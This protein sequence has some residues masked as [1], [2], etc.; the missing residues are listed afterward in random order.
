MLVVP[1]VLGSLVSGPS[2]RQGL[3]LI[4]WL[5]GY[6]AFFTTGVWLRSR[7]K[8]R[9]LPPVRVYATAELVL[10]AALL[11]SAPR[12]LHWAPAYAVLLTASLLASVRRADRSW[13][14]DVVT[15]AAASL[16]AAVAAGL[17][18][19]PDWDRAW[20]VT[21]I[22][23]GYF[24]GTVAYVKTMIRDRGSRPAYVWSVGYHAALAI[25]AFFVSLPLGFVAIALLLRAG[26]VPVRWPSATP[27]QVGLAEIAGTV[28]VVVATL[29]AV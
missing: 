27:K 15:V 11:A 3:L 20:L 21:A 1:P 8:A 14:N 29:V 5:V 28:A 13:F 24:I 26:A 4:T 12:L 9:Y 2:W 22:C 6:F 18:N 17:G 10:M 25:A 16:T 7:R 23:F 19:H